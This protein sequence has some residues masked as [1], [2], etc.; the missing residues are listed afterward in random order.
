MPV[1]VPSII[2]ATLLIHNIGAA[3]ASALQ[4]K[5]YAL[6]TA[7]EL[8]VIVTDTAAADAAAAITHQV[9]VHTRGG[10]IHRIPFTHRL[11]EPLHY[12]LLFPYGEEGW[13]KD[14]QLVPPLRP[15]ARRQRAAA[16]SSQPRERLTRL[17]YG[18]YRLMVRRGELNPILYSRRLGQEWIAGTYGAYESSRLD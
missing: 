6:P 14:L 18:A 3:E 10:G 8:A 17:Q 11:Y 16:A 13:H 1:S 4:R 7:N 2:E 15:P 5:R 12:V 9:V